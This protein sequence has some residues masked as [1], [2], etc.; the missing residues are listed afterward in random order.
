[1][2]YK[3]PEDKKAWN[4]RNK[5]KIA[6][7][8]KLWRKNNL[9]YLSPCI[10]ATYNSWRNYHHCQSDLRNIDM[11]PTKPELSLAIDYLSQA[12]GPWSSLPEHVKKTIDYCTQLHSGC[13]RTKDEIKE[14]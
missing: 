5:K 4:R 3:N 1:M 10:T 9:G 8:M 11:Q 6:E 12:N 14:Y 13:I 2:A 7:Y